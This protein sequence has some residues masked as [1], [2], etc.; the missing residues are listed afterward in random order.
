MTS[1]RVS[2]DTVFQE[3]R[4]GDGFETGSFV[5][6]KWGG[7][8]RRTTPQDYKPNA[9]R[10]PFLGAYFGSGSRSPERVTPF[11]LGVIGFLSFRAV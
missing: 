10:S 3:I 6:E 4:P 11:F 7:G 1:G 8:Y 2:R 5:K 9:G